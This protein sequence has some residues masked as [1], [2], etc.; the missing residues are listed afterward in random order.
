MHQPRL[1]I[2]K[3]RLSKK[4]INKIKIIRSKKEL[5]LRNI[6]NITV[7][8]ERYKNGV[9]SVSKHQFLRIFVAKYQIS[10]SKIFIHNKNILRR[11]ILWPLHEDCLYRSDV[12]SSSFHPLPCTTHWSWRNVCYS[13]NY[14]ILIYFIIELNWI[15]NYSISNLFIFIFWTF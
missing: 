13:K 8:Q 3:F 12:H 4:E 11:S 6:W 1:Q 14:K 9:K 7:F 15:W 2:L 5:D 10:Q